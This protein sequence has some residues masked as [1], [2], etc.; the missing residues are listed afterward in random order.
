MQ[1]LHYLAVI[2]SSQIW[3][4]VGS[5]LTE[6]QRVL[7]QGAVRQKL[8]YVHVSLQTLGSRHRK[9]ITSF[10]QSRKQGDVQNCGFP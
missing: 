2:C 3:C 1:Y 5:S 9:E 4:L 7:Q 8:C 6:G 10:V